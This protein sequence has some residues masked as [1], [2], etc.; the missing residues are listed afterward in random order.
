L[1]DRHTAMLDELE[2][3]ANHRQGAGR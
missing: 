1:C 3:A 2:K